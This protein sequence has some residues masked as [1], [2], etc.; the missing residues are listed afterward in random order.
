MSITGIYDFSYCPYALGDILTFCK[1]IQCL[2]L[3]YNQE[4]EIIIFIDPNIP[5]NHSQKIYINKDNYLN[6]FKNLI[7]LFY[8]I[9]KNISIRIFNNRRNFDFYCFKKI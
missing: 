9:K 1:K 5:S 8:L 4:P 6:Y 3:E 7:S 2:S